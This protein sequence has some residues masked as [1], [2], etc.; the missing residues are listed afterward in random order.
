MR[1]VTCLLS[2]RRVSSPSMDNL[3]A[4][5]WGCYFGTTAL[6]LAG[7][8][9]AYLRSVR[10]IARNAA[11]AACVSG[12]LVIAFL[13]GLPLTDD[14]VELR[15]L[16]HLTTAAAGILCFLLLSVLGVLKVRAYRRRVR[17]W[18]VLSCTLGIGAGWL[19]APINSL[20][21]GLSMA[22]LLGAVALAFSARSA[23][24][25][26][27]LAWAAVWAVL[28]ML[29]AIAGLGL[30]A[31]DRDNAPTLLHG[32]SA[33]AA[34]L[35][36]AT[37]ATLLWLR[38]SYLI[39]L[40]EVM[41]HG[42]SYDSITRMRSHTGTERLVDEVFSRLHDDA[43][44]V[45]LLVITIV[46]FYA[47]NKLHG[48]AAVNH[49]L[50]VSGGR[51]RRIVPSNVEVG[52][53]GRSGFVIMMRHCK[54]SGN[55]I[56]VAR[57]VSSRLSRPVQLNISADAS[58]LESR[59][60]AWAADMGIGVLVVSDRFRSGPDAIAIARATSRTAVGYASRIAWFDHPSGEI[61]E[62]PVLASC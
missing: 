60:T 7:S 42:P 15:F 12:F 39:V 32:V 52:R 37:M 9:F 54:D 44:P 6:M 26:D 11:L 29:V 57:L 23:T 22:L 34:T 10:R 14:S 13:G 55:L 8:V 31:L 17:L 56:D 35:Y 47:L 49:A 51:L 33:I 58:R 1:D 3:A 28:C 5:F 61:V 59:G 27:R 2:S 40:N 53:L 18:L 20:A 24:R 19:I 16:A 25:G 4:G 21:L 41:A 46:N 45:G 50:F 62:L 36:L 30:I 48:Q 43:V 38:Y